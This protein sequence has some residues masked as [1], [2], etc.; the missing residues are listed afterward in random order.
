MVSK[1]SQEEGEGICE[2]KSLFSTKKGRHARGERETGK[3]EEELILSGFSWFKWNG[4]EEK[5][6]SRRL[7]FWM[8][9]LWVPQLLTL[10]RLK[11]PSCGSRMRSTKEGKMLVEMSGFQKNIIFAHFWNSEIHAQI[12]RW[13][14]HFTLF[15]EKHGFGVQVHMG[16]ISKVVRNKM[17]PKRSKIIN[18]FQNW[19]PEFPYRHAMHRPPRA[20]PSLTQRPWN[21]PKLFKILIELEI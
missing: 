2:V 10:W 17:Q 12:L 16:K 19:Q 3:E 6:N 20:R 18:I 14:D 8:G 11:T 9:E 4:E 15:A 21:S 1:D 7:F 5:N 13:K